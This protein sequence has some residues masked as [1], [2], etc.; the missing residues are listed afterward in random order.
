MYIQDSE[1]SEKIA[2]PKALITDGAKT[3]GKLAICTEADGRALFHTIEGNTFVERFETYIDLYH[4]DR[5]GET[6]DRLIQAIIRSRVPG[7]TPIRGEEILKQNYA[8]K[9]KN[10]LDTLNKKKSD[11]PTLEE[12]RIYSIFF[13]LL[14]NDYASV[15][16]FKK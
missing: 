4:N 7:E 13:N 9:R 14:R 15:N 6:T 12:R 3:D 8:A 5:F 10:L 2:L 16:D 1:V 11:A